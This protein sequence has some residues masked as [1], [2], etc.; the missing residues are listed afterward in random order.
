MLPNLMN[1]TTTYQKK[2]ETMS[3]RGNNALGLFTCWTNR[4]FGVEWYVSDLQKP[5][6]VSLIRGWAPG[7]ARPKMRVFSSFRSLYRALQVDRRKKE[8]FFYFLF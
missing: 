4:V 1:D 3:A 5:K 8:S 2:R 7:A 6:S